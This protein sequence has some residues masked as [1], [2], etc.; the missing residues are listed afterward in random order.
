M[1]SKHLAIGIAG[2]IIGISAGAAISVAA[3][4][5]TKTIT[6]CVNKTTKVVTQKPTCT[7][8]ETRLQIAAQGPKGDPGA[9]GPAGPQG[10]EGPAGP[11]GPV[12]PVGPSG[13]GGQG[14]QGVPGP[15]GSAISVWDSFEDCNQKLNYALEA[16]YLLATK[17]DRDA[18]EAKSGCVVEEIFPSFRASI[19]PRQGSPGEAQG[20]PHIS[21]W[22]FLSFAPLTRPDGIEGV[23]GLPVVYEFGEAIYEVSASL[24]DG[25][26]FCQESSPSTGST[27]EGVTEDGKALVKSRLV[28]YMSEFYIMLEVGLR[29]GGG[30]CSSFGELNYVT[31]HEDPAKFIGTEHFQ[32]H[33]E[34]WGWK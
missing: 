27:L 8:S 4:T 13:D 18:F 30:A 17:R 32:D 1:N 33:L 28:A 20:Y 23:Y 19:Y 24:P 11:V 7:R 16:G 25:Y 6:L 34:W 29:T 31:V 5:P 14:P 26:E 22:E 3:N 21:S 9:I 15:A 2:L 12:G 10:L